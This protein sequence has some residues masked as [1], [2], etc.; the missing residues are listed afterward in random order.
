MIKLRNYKYVVIADGV[1]NKEEANVIACN[2]L[3]EVAD[4]FKQALELGLEPMIQEMSTYIEQSMLDRYVYHGEPTEQFEQELN[5]RHNTIKS[6][7]DRIKSR[8]V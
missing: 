1:V 2:N 8:Q 5:D 7:F 3:Y 6:L 4:A